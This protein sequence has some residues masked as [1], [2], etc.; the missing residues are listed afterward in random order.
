MS[1]STGHPTQTPPIIGYV[2]P[3][4]CAIGET[5]DF[6]ISSRD[7]LEFSAKVVRIDCADP[8]PSGP[9]MKLTPVSVD[10]DT[11]YSGK[12]QP[13]QLGSYGIARLCE[14][15]PC[16]CYGI[17]ITVKPTFESKSLQVI[18]TLQSDKGSGWS[19][20]L[21]DGT[22]CLL[23]WG[24]GLYTAQHSD[25]H[26]SVHQWHRLTAA[27]DPKTRRIALK[28]ESRKHANFIEIANLCFEEVNL[29][30]VELTQFVIAAFLRERQLHCFN[31]LIENPAWLKGRDLSSLDHM[32]EAHQWSLSADMSS[33]GVPALNPHDPKLELI[34][35]PARAVRSS[36]WT[37][38]FMN[39]KEA[40]DH[41]DA[42]FF[43]QDD[44]ADCE[45]ETSLHLTIPPH[46]ESGVYGLVI[47]NAEGTDIVPFYVV[48]K[49]NERSARICYLAS[50]LT[51]QAYANHA[52]SNFAG[53]LEQRVKEWGAFPHNPD[54]INEFGLS[55]YN[56]HV[57]G[58]GIHLSSR[59]RP[60]LSMRPGYLTFFDPRGSGLRHFV[61]DSHLTDWLRVKGWKFDVVTDEDLDELGVAVLNG[62]DVVITGTHPEYHTRRMLE[63]ILEYRES[64]GSFMYMGG[65]GFYWK[66]AREAQFPHIMEI[67]R[68]EGGIRAW[69]SEPGEYYNQLDGGYGGMWRRNGLAPQAIGGVGF[70]A[71]GTFEGSYY[72]RTPESEDPEISWLFEGVDEEKIGDYG[73]SG[74]GAAGFE[75]DQVSYQHGT[76][77]F[78]K[79]V[80][81]SYD[82]GPTFKKAPEEILTWTL[83][84]GSSNPYDGVCA[85]MVCG[86]SPTGAGL[87]A[88]GSITFL[89]SLSHNNYQNGVSKI[90]DNFLNKYVKST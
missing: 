5:L 73:L 34:N 74:G 83:S 2:T 68:A 19:L 9:G 28:V 41:Y 11:G 88:S 30:S 6:K 56:R 23:V 7:D 70:V 17:R 59:H 42:I 89:G 35:L 65:N 55:T 48:P 31:G 24:Q 49:P 58:V 79:I 53:D 77:D 3:L 57:D 61:A 75:L 54:V 51:Y 46:L 32:E 47:N 63:A 1:S 60:M 26:L 39:W 43:H 50:T 62:Y 40:P 36:A 10:L 44:L 13:V 85:H 52:R 82:H 67:R 14:L 45:W 80:A 12:Q 76:P 18:A 64:G 29:P 15:H 87:F 16:E 33:S 71:Q 90:V 78:L 66:I 69:A 21:R 25:L 8:N 4:R 20:A 22:L 86:E 72:K 81:V 27:Y 37:G 38:E 84:A